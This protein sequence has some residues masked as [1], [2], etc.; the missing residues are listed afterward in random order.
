VTST[1]NYT[2]NKLALTGA[3]IAGVTT[4]YGTPAA[5]GVV[6][7][8][9][10][11]F[12]DQV[13]STASINSP[14]YSG[15]SN[16]NAGSYMQ[17]ASSLG[18][19]DAGNY[20]FGGVTSTANY[21]VSPLNLSVTGVTAA[22]KVYDGTTAASLGG[23]GVVVALAGDDVAVGGTGTGVFADANAGTAKP[24]NISGFTLSG[25][26]ASNY[27]VVQPIG[28]TADITSVSSGGIPPIVVQAITALPD[29]T[30]L[31]P[32]FAAAAFTVAAPVT[33]FAP[34]VV[35]SNLQ[36][37]TMTAPVN[38]L[39]NIEPVNNSVDVPVQSQGTPQIEGFSAPLIANGAIQFSSTVAIL[40][41]GIRLPVDSTI[42][43]RRVINK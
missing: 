33:V 13:T 41:G 36:Y 24:V 10:N 5:A 16:L 29:G 25:T 31:L 37:V 19:N 22:N 39:G 35:I 32:A 42:S 2:V 40:N 23:T 8:G 21:T 9:N 26:D 34:P 27:T 28:V 30:S 17:T 14:I 43:V 15:S 20:T 3:A 1:A 12:G 38:Q 18:G 4:T 11:L 7:F 6:T